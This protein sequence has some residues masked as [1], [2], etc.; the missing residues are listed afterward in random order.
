DDRLVAV[1]LDP[2]ARDEPAADG[3]MGALDA[4][5]DDGHRHAAATRAEPL[6]RRGLDRAPAGQLRQSPVVERLAPREHDAAR[7]WLALAGHRRMRRVKLRRWAV[8]A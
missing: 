7:A 4:R 1:H 6:G 5:V 2:D 3:G 8:A